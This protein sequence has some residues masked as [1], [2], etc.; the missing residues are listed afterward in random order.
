MQISRRAQF[1][2]GGFPEDVV[3]KLRRQKPYLPISVGLIVIDQQFKNLVVGTPKAEHNPQDTCAPV[4]IQERLPEDGSPRRLATALTYALLS[5]RINQDDLTYLGYGHGQHRQGAICRQ[6]G[7]C[8]LWFGYCVTPDIRR[9]GN[10]KL[11]KVANFSCLT[12]MDIKRWQSLHIG[13]AVSDSKFRM[14][15]QALLVFGQ[16]NGI[17]NGSV[18]TAHRVLSEHQLIPQV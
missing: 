8:V 17:S 3:S 4:P 10:T 12:W 9:R 11:H 1:I 6:Y 15:M 2:T 7:K 14:V 5:D 16:K 18:A 13:E